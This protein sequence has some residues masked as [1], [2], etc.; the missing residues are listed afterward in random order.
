MSIIKHIT[1]KFV[2]SLGVLGKILIWFFLFF[3]Y[4]TPVYFLPLPSWTDT[5]IV[6]ILMNVGAWADLLSLPLW[7][8][9]FVEVINQPF[10]C[11]SYVFLVFFAIYA[12]I[13]AHD[14]IVFL[15]L[16]IQ[17][18]SPNR[19]LHKQHRSLKILLLIV[20][21]I[22]AAY[23]IAWFSGD[24]L[25]AFVKSRI[26]SHYEHLVKSPAPTPSSTV[27]PPK[28]STRHFVPY[29]GYFHDYTRPGY[30]LNQRS[31]KLTITVPDNHP[32]YCFVLA[33]SN[34]PSDKICAIIVH[35]GET[36]SVQVPEVSA[37]IYYTY[38]TSNYWYGFDDFC[39]VNGVWYSSDDVFDFSKYEWTITLEKV[40][41]GNWDPQP[42]NASKVP[43]L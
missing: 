9:A 4:F 43:F 39:G 8:W 37:A 11:L 33:K 5:L 3:F 32:F 2:T 38:S 15:K 24:V 7:A 26:A 36:V 23:G 40:S 30:G 27:K 25:P 41:D 22:V 31:S 1:E 29:N 35:G 20:S 34:N 14:L 16:I 17:Y 28:Q 21:V 10:D 42:V 13:A 6:L 12:V 18:K 19:Q